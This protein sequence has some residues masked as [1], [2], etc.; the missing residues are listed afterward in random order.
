[1]STTKR[2]YSRDICWSHV[3]RQSTGKRHDQ[4][5]CNYCGSVWYSSDGQRVRKHLLKCPSI[6][7][8]VRA[9]FEQEARQAQTQQAT[10]LLQGL[11]SSS[12]TTHS[13]QPV[14]YQTSTFDP[15]DRPSN[16]TQTELQNACA[17]W[18]YKSG[19][20]LTTTEHPAFKTLMHNLN[21][22][23]APPNR[24]MLAESHAL[25]S[26]IDSASQG[27]L[28][29]TLREICDRSDLGRD[30]ATSMLLPQPP[31]PATE[32]GPRGTR[33]G[34]ESLEE[35]D[36][37]C[38]HCNREFTGRMQLVRDCMY[39][40]GKFNHPIKRRG[41]TI[42]G[43]HLTNT[44]NKKGDKGI[45]EGSHLWADTDYDSPSDLDWCKEVE[46]FQEG[47]LWTCCQQTGE[48]EGCMAREHLVRSSK[49]AR[50]QGQSA[51]RVP[52]V[53]D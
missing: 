48:K 13:A 22:G 34:A 44:T 7:P 30:I 49:A 25:E 41:T 32:A 40:P 51:N 28:A 38:Q 11:P 46:E 15:I 45:D 17:R 5:T 16:S 23:F 20:P 12:A 2:V 42:S 31:P 21:P 4:I 1:M 50:V 26:A 52:L 8:E 35:I 47:F 53:I 9:P 43:T 37:V 24:R 27:I 36:R 18:I 19:L 6:P 33:R 14:A 10:Q 39:H 3:K 29:N